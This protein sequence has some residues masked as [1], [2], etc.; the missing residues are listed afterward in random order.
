MAE[1]AIG[2][3][4]NAVYRVRVCR[5]TEGERLPLVVDRHGLPVPLA[6]QWSLLIRRPR[7]QFN[8]LAEELRTVAHVCEWAET[9]NA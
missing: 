9:L 8:S 7:L 4:S 1:R 2:G 6:N 3:D 5:M